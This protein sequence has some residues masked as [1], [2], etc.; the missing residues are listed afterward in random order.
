M[1]L[2]QLLE[3][4]RKDHLFTTLKKLT[5]SIDYQLRHLIPS[6]EVVF[7][8]L[9]ANPT[10]AP[11]IQGES[12]EDILEKWFNKY[13]KG[14]EKRA[15]QRSSN[16]PG[17]VPDPII[18]IILEARLPHLDQT[19]LK[20]IIHGH[21]IAMSAENIL[22]PM[23]EEYLSI[24]LEPFGWFCCWGET[25]R[26]VDFANRDGRLLQVKNRS[27]SENSSSS[28]VRI[29]TDIEKWFRVNAT[30]GRYLW[31]KLKDINN[32]GNLNEQNFMEF[33]R[34]VLRNNNSALAVENDNPWRN[35]L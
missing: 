13:L 32:A 25:L 6:I 27:N 8:A 15:S 9:Q 35:S 20:K 28:R 18:E 24:Q 5:G 34:N 4:T 26:S 33:A 31:D 11:K 21:R 7:G 3:N 19:S 23:L 29:G 14:Y 22:G 12:A 10:L 1:Y 30:S 16:L 2:N 17:T